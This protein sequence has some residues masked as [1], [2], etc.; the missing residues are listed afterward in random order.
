ML[1]SAPQKPPL[2][3]ADSLMDALPNSDHPF[4][5]AGQNLGTYNST[6]GYWWPQWIRLGSRVLA[7]NN[8]S[9]NTIFLHKDT[10]GSS[11][12]T[13]DQ[14]GTSV[15]QHTLFYP[16]GQLWAYS[17]T[18]YEQGFAA[19]YGWDSGSSLYPTLFRQY[20]PRLGRWQRFWRQRLRFLGEDSAESFAFIRTRP[21]SIL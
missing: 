4:D 20:E 2:D 15:V 1:D 19:F 13:T 17:G 12:I 3:T 11:H 21:A 9:Y 6:G 5:V 7:F 14:S 8:G 16:W 10:L 18:L